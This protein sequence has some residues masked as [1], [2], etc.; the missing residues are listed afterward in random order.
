MYAVGNTAVI[1]Y[2]AT[3]R[4]ALATHYWNQSFQK[5]YL[6]ILDQSLYILKPAVWV[7]HVFVCP[8]WLSDSLLSALRQS[9]EA[10]AKRRFGLG[11]VSFGF[12]LSVGHSG[13]F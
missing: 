13:E 5:L 9:S 6:F 11:E 4:T 2:R 1:A 10:A 7:A 8:F 12:D 3:S